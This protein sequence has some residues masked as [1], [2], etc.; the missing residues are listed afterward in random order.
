[1]GRFGIGL[2][3]AFE[4]IEYPWQPLSYVLTV[5]FDAAGFSLSEGSFD[6]AS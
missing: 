1:L 3:R 6:H 4:G 5:L 2:S